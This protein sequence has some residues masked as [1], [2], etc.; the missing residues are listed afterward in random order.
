MKESLI[1]E[2]GLYVLPLY[3]KAKLKRWLHV[4]YGCLI[5]IF[6][7]FVLI[8]GDDPQKIVLNIMFIVFAIVFGYI[9]MSLAY[10]NKPYILVV[11]QHFEYKWLFGHVVIEFDQ[12]EKMGCF[13][14]NGVTMFGIWTRHLSKPS[15]WQRTDRLFGKTYAV[16]VV[17]STFSN[18]DFNVLYSTILQ[19]AGSA[20]SEEQ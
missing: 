3:Q 7:G 4:L 15:F 6:L 1:K 14:E 17:V 19:K 20:N 18:I 8:P 13:S 5:A 2:N 16:K 12:I 10:F 9:W 11:D